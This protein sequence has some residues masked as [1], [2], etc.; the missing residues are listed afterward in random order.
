MRV[1]RTKPG[2]TPALLGFSVPIFLMPS[3]IGSQDLASLLTRK[4]EIVSRV[5]QHLINSPFGTIHAATFRFPNPVG[6]AIPPAASLTR[7]SLVQ[8]EDADGFGRRFA[9]VFE[10]EPRWTFPSVDRS[11]KGDRLIAPP[12]EQAAGADQESG[13]AVAGLPRDMS[14]RAVAPVV[15]STRANPAA[16]PASATPSTNEELAGPDNETPA[17]SEDEDPGVRTARVYFGVQPMGEG[18]ASIQPWGPGETPILETPEV[19]DLDFKRP[20]SLAP[21]A[22]GEPT[23]GESIAHKGEVTGEGQ[24]PRTPAERLGLS[25]SARAKAEKCLS[26]AIYF[27]ARGEPVRGQIAVAQVVWNR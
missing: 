8:G 19:A 11:T 13:P 15:P 2:W 23:A 18:F 4:T 20:E 24:R 21:T 7:V 27:E 25:G 6:S 10:P 17:F 26:D 12:P 1:A 22:S 16:P 5:E 3:A 14:A 9:G